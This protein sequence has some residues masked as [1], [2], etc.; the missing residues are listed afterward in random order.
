MLSQLIFYEVSGVFV[1]LLGCLLLIATRRW[2]EG[3]TG[4]S[5]GGVQ[6]MHNE[7][8][9]RIGGVAIYL[10]MVCAWYFARGGV[11]GLIGTLLVAGLPAFVFGLLE[12]LSNK[13]G[14]RLRLL[15]TAASG[16]IACFMS[17]ASLSHL[18]VWGLDQLLQWLPLSI[19]F[20]AFAIA[21]VAN[22]FNVID[23]LNGLAS[24][25]MTLVALGLAG[26]ALAVGDLAL[27]KVCLL[28][29]G[30]VLGFLVVNLLT[31]KIFLGDGGAYFTGFALAWLAVLLVERNDAVSPFAVLLIFIKPVFEV[32]FSVFRR[33]IRGHAPTQADRLH[34]HSLFLRRYLRRWLAGTSPRIINSTGG[35]L[36]ALL[37]LP[38]V[39]FAQ[40]AF[41]R[42][43]LCLAAILVVVLGYLTLYARMVRHRWCSPIAFL[44][45]KP[46]FRRKR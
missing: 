22:A 38:P 21:G 3:L 7:P 5:H 9:L 35:F 26:I 2:H 36:I 42:T 8:A 24:G 45:E 27:A 1:S 18:D 40:Q 44:L 14:I 13:I 33:M 16:I 12:D 4:D 11:A 6:N 10:G 32:L 34:F 29:G 31:G 39:V 20:T 19:A 30:V 25:T 37:T 28:L 15:A 23:G 46:V 43:D 41:D 17:G